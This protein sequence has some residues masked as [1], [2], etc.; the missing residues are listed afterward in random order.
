VSTRQV[1]VVKRLA[2]QPAVR[3]AAG[4]LRDCNL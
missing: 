2:G 1:S 4:I 3:M